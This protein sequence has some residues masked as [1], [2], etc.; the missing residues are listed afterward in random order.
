MK[1]GNSFY[2]ISWKSIINSSCK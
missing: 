2:G 1:G